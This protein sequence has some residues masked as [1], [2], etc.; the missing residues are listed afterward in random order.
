MQRFFKEERQLGRGQRGGVFLCQ[1]VLHG[2]ELSQ[3]AVKKISVGA[4]AKSLLATLKEVKYLESL[5]HANIIS[6]H[7]SWLE[8]YAHSRLGPVVPTLFLLLEFANGGR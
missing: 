5:R 3:Y 1:H 2:N 6:Y 7:H 8:M 4:S